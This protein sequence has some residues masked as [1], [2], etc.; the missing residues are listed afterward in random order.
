MLNAPDLMQK[1]KREKPKNI[2]ITIFNNQKD[3]IGTMNVN[4][5]K[6]LKKGR[7]AYAFQV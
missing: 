5:L 6:G 7:E 4:R 3:R 1:S 2:S